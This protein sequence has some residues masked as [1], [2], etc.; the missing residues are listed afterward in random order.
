MHSGCIHGIS[1]SG[2][3]EV[4]KRKAPQQRTVLQGQD[5]EVAAGSLHRC[6]AHSGGRAGSERQRLYQRSAGS[7]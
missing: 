3:Q 4:G 5:W 1:I 7:S 6:V 2:P